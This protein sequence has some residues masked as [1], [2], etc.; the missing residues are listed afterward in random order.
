MNRVESLLTRYPASK[1]KFVAPLEEPLLRELLADKPNR[2]A[3][4]LG[5]SRIA[6]ELSAVLHEPL[7]ETAALYHDVGY[8]PLLKIADFHPFDGA[9]FLAQMRADERVVAAVLGHSAAALRAA[10]K[11]EVSP[12]YALMDLDPEDALTDL[13]TFC[14]LRSDQTGNMVT[15][16]ERVSEAILRHGPTSVLAKYMPRLYPYY[17]R[18][19]D[20]VLAMLAEHSPHP[21]PWLF[22]DVD[23]T[24]IMPGGKLSS[25]NEAAL[26]AYTDA[27]G[28]ISLA[29]GRHPH[30]IQALAQ[31]VGL[32][33]PHLAGNGSIVIEDGLCMLLDSIASHV[34]ALDEYLRGEGIPFA[35]YSLEGVS[36]TSPE[37]DRSHL[38]LLLAID[39][40]VPDR[41]SAPDWERVFKILMFIPKDAVDLE[42]S[43]RV[44][45]AE[46]G[47]A[48]V[49][50]AHDF[51]E[52]IS[53]KSG[54]D[55]AMRQ[56]LQSA[57]WPVFH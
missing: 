51:L 54:K 56:I 36:V 18:T 32:P 22:I 30:A 50:T 6:R 20:R 38:N 23:S 52:L 24:L 5:S 13:V 12:L 57:G 46:M 39:E 2:L 17:Q 53:M 9:V 40:P 43:V 8:S 37:V 26:K 16:A 49:R 42:A 28:R 11:P 41:E 35:L 14:D 7:L 55:V 45:A 10:D 27:G 15:V 48:C 21:L 3:H 29:T 34:R 44:K 31:A 33:G 1:I 19:R 47:V 25:R 4:L